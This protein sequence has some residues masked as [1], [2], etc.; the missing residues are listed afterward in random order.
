MRTLFKSLAIVL[1]LIG[2]ASA[3]VWWNYDAVVTMILKPQTAA[4]VDI[5]EASFGL[6][7]ADGKRFALGDLEGALSSFAPSDD[8]AARPLVLFVH[9]FGPDPDGEFG[10]YTMGELAKGAGADVLM[11]NWPSWISMTEFPV[12]NA[13]AASERL[14][15]LLQKIV[16]LRGP[17]QALAERPVMIVGHSMAGKSSATWPRRRP[18]CPRA[19]SRESSSPSRKRPCLIIASGWKSSPSPTR[20]SSSSTPT[21]RP[22]K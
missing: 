19:S 13:R 17:G 1:A 11:F 8:G 22:C 20:S 7:T 18:T 5:T 2:A 10:L 3:Y 6:V 12:L 21:T 16:D 9:G 15:T 4:A 14:I